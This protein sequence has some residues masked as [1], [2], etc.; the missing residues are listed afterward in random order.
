MDSVTIVIGVT[1]VLLGVVF[2]ALSVNSKKKKERQILQIL[3]G[4]TGN[5]DCKISKYDIL[6][7]AVIGFDE[8]SNSVVV[9]RNVA[10]EESSQIINL[11]EI[12]RCRVSELSRSFS[13]KEGTIKAFDRIDLVFVNKDK[14][15]TGCFGGVLQCGDRP[16][17]FSRGATVSC[18]V[19]CDSYRQNSVVLNEFVKI[20]LPI[21]LRSCSKGTEHLLNAKVR[22][23]GMVNITQIPMF[24]LGLLLFG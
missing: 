2:Y 15:T 22:S 18:E 24:S 17:Y 5:D 6:N 19:V 14:N 20:V 12:Q 10:G 3:A 13:T 1:L 9:S 7:H 21:S 8:F 23:L 4:V 16:A 11:A